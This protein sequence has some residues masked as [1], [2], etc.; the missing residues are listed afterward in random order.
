[1]QGSPALQRAGARMTRYSGLVKKATLRT[2]TLAWLFVLAQFGLLAALLLVPPWRWAWQPA[3]V[4]L[5]L[6]AVLL[7]AWTLLHNRPGN[8]NV[9]PQPRAQGHLVTDGPYRWMRHPM[10]VT[11]LLGAAGWALCAGGS[12]RALIVLALLLVLNAKAALEERL[13]L[14][15]WPEY[16]AYRARTRRFVPGLW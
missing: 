10:Y 7:G 14:A 5:L 11:V 2:A 4:V 16:A 1:H 3:G 9:R 12:G 8:F 13:L 15:R 6:L